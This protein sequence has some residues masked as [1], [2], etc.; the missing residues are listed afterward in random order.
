MPPPTKPPTKGKAAATAGKAGA[1]R[2]SSAS[3]AGQPAP[4]PPPSPAEVAERAALLAQAKALRSARDEDEA[5]RAAFAREKEHLA[6]QW[7][8]TKR[9]LEERRALLLARSRERDEADAAFEVEALGYEARLRQLARQHAA[10]ATDVTLEGQEA[11][12]ARRAAFHEEADAADGAS[13]GA[14]STAGVLSC[15]ETGRHTHDY[16]RT[17]MPASACSRLPWRVGRA[18][19]HGHGAAGVASVRRLR[20]LQSPAMRRRGC[21][22][23]A[24]RTARALANPIPAALAARSAWRTTVSS[25]SCA[26]RSSRTCMT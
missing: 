1:A 3:K 2:G 14:R 6:S 24:L 25:R 19:E 15:R 13:L 16:H 8:A 10:E 7:A 21:A 20:A 26:G 12:A 23:W 11:L 5:A 17:P 18:Q 22:R 9:V 4:P